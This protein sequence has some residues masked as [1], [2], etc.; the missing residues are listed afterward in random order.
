MVE[1]EVAIGRVGVHMATSV[2][3]TAAEGACLSKMSLRVL[4]RLL[5]CVLLATAFLLRVVPSGVPL[6][7]A[8]T[9]S[10]SAFGPP[11][12]PTGASKFVH[13]PSRDDGRSRCSLHSRVALGFDDVFRGGRGTRLRP[14]PR[15]LPHRG[16][17]RV[18]CVRTLA[19]RPLV[20]GSLV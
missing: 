19:R 13:T 20:R 17:A 15:V 14:R 8:P 6:R 12:D 10:Q 1:E 9:R 4:L 3:Q 11:V 2:G 5:L 16:D 7:P 18:V